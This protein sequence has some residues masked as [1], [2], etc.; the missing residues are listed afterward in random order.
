MELEFLLG[1]ECILAIQIIGASGARSIRY[2]AL[3]RGIYFLGPK[4]LADAESLLMGFL[5]DGPRD[6][7]TCNLSRSLKPQHSATV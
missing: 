5:S 6:A 1:M 7:D 2:L 4:F 3:D